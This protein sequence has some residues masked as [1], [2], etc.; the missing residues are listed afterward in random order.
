MTAGGQGGIAAPGWLRDEMA[1]AATHQPAGFRCVAQR[2]KREEEG[3]IGGTT[4]PGVE[5]QLDGVWRGRNTGHADAE[6]GE[7]Q[8]LGIAALVAEFG[9]Q[10][11]Q[12]GQSGELAGVRQLQQLRRQRGGPGED[13][14]P[15]AHAA[16]LARTLRIV[17]SVASGAVSGVGFVQ[18][19]YPI[20]RD[21][22]G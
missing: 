16:V 9:Q 14:A 4:P 19:N 20:S 13:V 21:Q 18:P 3:R 2:G 12:D 15:G 7:E 17:A 1:A 10:E 6:Q 5:E 22:Q 8:R 11:Q